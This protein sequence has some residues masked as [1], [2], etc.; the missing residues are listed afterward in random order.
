LKNSTPPNSRAQERTSFRDEIES[1]EKWSFE[2]DKYTDFASLGKPSN[3][4]DDQ[5]S[6]TLSFSTSDTESLEFAIASF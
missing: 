4:P 5:R 2:M 3:D 1:T 6:S